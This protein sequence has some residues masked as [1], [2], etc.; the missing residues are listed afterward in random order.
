MEIVC[1]APA[2]A[3]GCRMNACLPQRLVRIDVADTCHRTLRQQIRLDRC[4]SSLQPRRELVRIELVRQWLRTQ[5]LECGNTPVVTRFDNRHAAESA[6]IAECQRASVVE[7]QPSTHI[8]IIEIETKRSRHPEM[9]YELQ[10]G[11]ERR[12]HEL[13][14][15]TNVTDRTPRDEADIGEFPRNG[16]KRVP[17]RVQHP[18]TGQLGRELTSHRLDLGQLGHHLKRSRPP[19][20]DFRDI[21]GAPGTRDG[22][23]AASRFDRQDGA[24]D[25]RDVTTVQLGQYSRE[26]A[27]AIAGELEKAEILW[28]HKAPG[29]FSRLWEYGVRLFVDRSRLEEALAIARR[30]TEKPS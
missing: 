26:Q 17:P 29:F 19:E 2:D 25:E 21:L 27:N 12:Q 24:M 15:A 8:G 6:R 22:A 16:G 7:P 30:I 18:P 11:I 5:Q 14:P 4:R 1:P 20:I 3:P 23:G 9:E 10:A 13:A 28:W